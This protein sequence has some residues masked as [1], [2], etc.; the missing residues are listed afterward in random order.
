MLSSHSTHLWR[1]AAT[2]HL[3]VIRYRKLPT[4]RDSTSMHQGRPPTW[5]AWPLQSTF[6][7]SVTSSL[8]AL[9]SSRCSSVP[10]VNTCKATADGAA[11]T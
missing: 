1:L 6:R 10:E 5:G 11:T 4:Q 2:F 8:T 9:H 3:K 7:S